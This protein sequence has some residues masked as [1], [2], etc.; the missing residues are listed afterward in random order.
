VIRVEEFA[1]RLCRLGSDRGPR[2]FPRKRRDR[3]ILMQSIVMGLDGVRTYT[4]PQINALLQKW[5]REL[6]PA[7]DVDHVTLRRYLVDAGRLERTAD[8]S[9]DRV[10]FP[11]GMVAFGVEIFD[12]DLR[13]TV[14]AFVDA[15]KRRK[16]PPPKAR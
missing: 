16:R 12:L 10:G 4:E 14:A 8:G 7:I 15:Q 2:G 11:P 5:N 9:R 3:E 1:E 6:A 13:A